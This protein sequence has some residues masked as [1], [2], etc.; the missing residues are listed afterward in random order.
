LRA[1]ELVPRERRSPE[2]ELA[3]WRTLIRVG[4]MARV[5]EELHRQNGHASPS[6]ELLL[7]RGQIAMLSGELAVAQSTLEGLLKRPS[8]NLRI[9]ASAQ[10]ALARTLAHLG[11]GE[12]ARRQLTELER[13]TQ[14]ARVAFA[15]ALGR[16]ES[17]FIE[18]RDDE[19]DEAIHR[20]R[21]FADRLSSLHAR[22]IVP[23]LVAAIRARQGR[24]Q[25]AEEALKS[26]ERELARPEDVILRASLRFLRA[27]LLF[28]RGDRTAALEEF[29]NLGL[30][31]EQNRS[32]LLALWAQVHAGRVM[33]AIGQREQGYRQLQDVER[34]ARERGI[35]SVQRMVER[36][37]V[38]DPLNQ[39]QAGPT[40]PPQGRRGAVVRAR[41]MEALRAAAAGEGG[42]SLL[43][44]EANAGQDGGA[45]YAL[46][47]AIGH[48]A[49]AT[50]ARLQGREV[51]ADES[52][53][54]ANRE[55]ASEAVD[56]ELLP[57]LASAV[58]RLR[59]VTGAERRFLPDV[60]ADLER[61]EV[62]L[63]GR[64]HELRN[65]QGAISLKSRPVLRR[66]LYALAGRPNG[67]FT[68]EEL[69]RAIWSGAYNAMVHD[70]ALRV[71]IK[72]LR[73]LLDGSGLAVDLQENGYSLAVPKDFL[74]IDSLERE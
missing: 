41:A 44:L 9:K 73:A 64:T 38:L 58:G 68:K 72:N 62:V 61:Y 6:D 29:R 51:E 48:L 59:A 26:A 18:E 34:R 74:F 52:L 60:P 12:E 67:A 33:L 36:S 14:D 45:G 4:E 30:A 70:N 7:L 19:A 69:A 42:R 63:D 22:V 13:E 8:L 35:V 16:L 10:L 24:M 40:N 2:L 5:Q 25:D 31:A 17:L 20:A 50:L 37:S 66:L 23:A 11:H 71:N 21:E 1:Y 27:N 49:R 53:G 39:L 46:D 43:L 28:E 55:A 32:L 3:R 56:A 57:A 15:C 65:R 47:R 54:R